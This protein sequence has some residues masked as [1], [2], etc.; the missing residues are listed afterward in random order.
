M[1]VQHVS[2]VLHGLFGVDPS[3]K[4]IMMIL[5]EHA[6]RDTALAWPSISTLAR[7]SCLKPR[8]VQN[9]VHNLTRGGWLSLTQPSKGGRGRCNIYRINIERLIAV[10]RGNDAARQMETVTSNGAAEC[11]V[12]DKASSAAD[13]MATA[14]N[15]IRQ[16][17]QSDPLNHADKR[18]NGAVKQPETMQPAAPEPVLGRYITGLEPGGAQAA[19]TSR[20]R[21][22]PLLRKQ[23]IE[24]VPQERKRDASNEMTEEAIAERKRMLREQVET[25]KKAM[26]AQS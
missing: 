19:A 25:L 20:E 24:P 11:A 14:V 3:A 6:R 8:Q 5:A 18:G 4:L 22:T 12:S 23:E 15:G 7:L 17:M 10:R 1:A 13:R 2:A 9:I 21:S 16:T 26:A